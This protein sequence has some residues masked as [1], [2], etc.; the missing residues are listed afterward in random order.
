MTCIASFDGVIWKTRCTT[1]TPSRIP[2]DG[3][4][5]PRP[6]FPF[7]ENACSMGTR[8]SSKPDSEAFFRNVPTAVASSPTLSSPCSS[9]WPTTRVGYAIRTLRARSSVYAATRS[10]SV[11]PL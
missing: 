6:P 7:A 5:S 9:M 11:A 2:S 4:A 3:R 1:R 8:P 10:S